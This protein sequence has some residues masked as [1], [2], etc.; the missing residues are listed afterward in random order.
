MIL[1]LTW[2]ALAGEDCLSDDARESKH[3]KTTILQFIDLVFSE[4]RRVGAK[5]QWVKGIVS[6]AIH[7]NITIHKKLK[8]TWLSITLIEV[9]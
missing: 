2:E 7:L 4:V 1:L 9:N 3:G 8:Q 5:L 6:L